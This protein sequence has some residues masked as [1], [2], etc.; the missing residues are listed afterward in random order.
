[1]DIRYFEVS[2]TRF[3]VLPIVLAR[4]FSIAP[5]AAARDMSNEEALDVGIPIYV[6]SSKQVIQPLPLPAR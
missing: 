6:E 4:F 3:C 5:G 2:L 1:M